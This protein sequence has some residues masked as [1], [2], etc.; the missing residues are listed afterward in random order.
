MVEYR[1]AE[2]ELWNNESNLYETGCN[3]VLAKLSLFTNCDEPS[4]VELVSEF[5]TFAEETLPDVIDPR[6]E[7]LDVHRTDD[8]VWTVYVADKS[9]DEVG[10]ATL[11]RL[12]DRIAEFVRAKDFELSISRLEG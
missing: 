7:E 8:H 2:V 4:W 6:Y 5:A 3:G 9:D 1:S 10:E 11:E 12:R